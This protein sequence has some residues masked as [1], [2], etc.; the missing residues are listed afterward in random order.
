MG[1]VAG[2]TDAKWLHRNTNA[3]G[4]HLVDVN[5]VCCAACAY[6]GGNRCNRKRL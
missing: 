2:S 1:V 3:H 6:S 5:V 4:A